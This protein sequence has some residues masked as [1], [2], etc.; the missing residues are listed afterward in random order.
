ML[1]FGQLAFKPSEQ[2]IGIIRECVHKARHGEVPE[3]ASKAYAW[4]AAQDYP[5]AYE[6]DLRI[7]G[8][9]VLGA[10]VVAYLLKV[11]LAPPRPSPCNVWVQML[12]SQPH[13][14]LPVC[15][16]PLQK[17][18]FSPAATCVIDLRR[19]CG[20]LSARSKVYGSVSWLLNVCTPR[21]LVLP[22]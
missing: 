5:L 18:H 9:A 14:A 6:V 3:A 15:C 19:L 12:K 22:L 16:G 10:A 21:A 20:D 8:S 7:I 17:H 2:K 11:S 4:M 1:A 13:R